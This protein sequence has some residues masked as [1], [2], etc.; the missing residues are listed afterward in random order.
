MERL[1]S[2]A[3]R[4]TRSRRGVIEALVRLQRP[5]TP[6]EI[7]DAVGE[8]SCDLATVYRS[9]A[10]FEKLGMVHRIDLGDGL[11]RFEIA[12]NDPH[13]HH[14]HH[15]VCRECERI[16]QLDDC[17]LAE[18]ET[19]LSRHYG[20]KQITHRLEFFGVCPDCQR[21]R[22]PAGGAQRTRAR[23]PRKP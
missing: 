18:M 10:L 16:I 22:P 3:G 2:Q 23:R 17:I 14:H 20:F 6:R 8:G 19:R 13:G 5:S 4:V 9:M 12:D 7:A 11:A 15:L 21:V 1:R